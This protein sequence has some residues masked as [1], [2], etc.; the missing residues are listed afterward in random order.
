MLLRAR[1]DATNNLDDGGDSVDRVRGTL[2][3]EAVTVRR[4]FVV[5]S[6]LVVRCLGALEHSV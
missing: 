3:N 4:R 1:R 2:V 5:P 6:L